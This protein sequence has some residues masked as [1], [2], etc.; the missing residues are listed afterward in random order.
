VAIV[1]PEAAEAVLA[2]CAGT[3]YSTEAAIVGRVI[4]APPGGDD[5]DAA[6]DAAD[7]GY[8]ERG[9]ATEDLLGRRARETSYGTLSVPGLP[10]I[11]DPRG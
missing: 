9:V 6:G 10:Y 2:P 5:E 8:A 4:E 3:K 1:A 11:Y 7:S